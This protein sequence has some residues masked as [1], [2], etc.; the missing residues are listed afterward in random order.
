[1]AS[2][3]ACSSAFSTGARLA[4]RPTTTRTPA[5][6]TSVRVQAAQGSKKVRADVHVTSPAGQRHAHSVVQTGTAAAIA[7]TPSCELSRHGTQWSGR[8]SSGLEGIYPVR[9]APR[10]L[11]DPCCSDVRDR[12]SVLTGRWVRVGAGTLVLIP[13]TSLALTVVQDVVALGL[14][15]VGL[16]LFA[17]GYIVAVITE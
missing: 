1:M 14:G 4:T 11:Y 16:G 13:D 10:K 17:G 9:S 3:S 8:I 2:L 6:S 7:P 15:G 5:R 12:Q